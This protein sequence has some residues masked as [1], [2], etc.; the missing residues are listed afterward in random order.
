MNPR[1]RWTTAVSTRRTLPG[2]IALLALI[3]AGCGGP[4]RDEL[5]P[6]RRARAAELGGAAADALARTLGTRLSAALSQ[7]GAVQAL[8][9][10]SGRAQDL[11]DSVT[12]SLAGGI[13]VGRISLQPRNPADAPDILDREVLLG[14]QEAASSSAPLPAEEIRAAPSGEVRYYRPLVVTDLCMQCHGP[15]ETLAPAVREV[16]H[17]RYPDD[18]AVGY[19]PGDV[20][21]A[22][23]VRIPPSALTSRGPGEG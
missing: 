7:G 16:L 18:R 23:R 21:G 11:T 22:I 4:P 8:V 14:F 12:A 19:H 15:P 17:A 1:G 20:R 9:F 2:A 6:G 10:C 3:L 13:R 5:D